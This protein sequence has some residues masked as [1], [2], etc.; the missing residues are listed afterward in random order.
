MVAGWV[1][2]AGRLACLCCRQE[3]MASRRKTLPNKQCSVGKCVY[4]QSLTRAGLEPHNR[5]LLPIRAQQVSQN[6][7]ECSSFTSAAAAACRRCPSRPYAARAFSAQ[8]HCHRR[9][10]ACRI[11]W[12][13]V[14]AAETMP[15]GFS[16]ALHAGRWQTVPL[17]QVACPLQ[18]V[19]DSAQVG[20]GGC[21]L[22]AIFRQV[23]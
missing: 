17:F 4:W 7:G 19:C 8:R 16:P 9:P 3:G 15:A 14:G 1:G 5:V 23:K 2:K 11:G 22:A 12:V 13:V 6:P 21:H 20:D 10:P 18:V